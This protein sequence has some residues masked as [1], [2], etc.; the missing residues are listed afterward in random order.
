MVCE[1]CGAAVSPERETV[2]AAEFRAALERQRAEGSGALFRVAGVPYRLV[3]RVAEGRHAEVLLAERAARLTERVVVKVVR[4]AAHADRLAHEWEV[5]CALQ[6]STA[7]GAPV[8]SQWVPQPVARGAFQDGSAEEHP[9]LVL[10]ARSGFVHTLEH[11]RAAYPEGVD[12]RHATWMWRR[13]LDVLGWA[14]R[15]G[16]VHRAVE[17]GHVLIH[18][19]DHG[20]MLVGWADARPATAATRREDLAAAARCVR[21]ALGGASVPPALAQ[22]LGAWADDP[23]PDDDAWALSAQVASAARDAWGPPRFLPFS[24]PGWR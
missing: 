15:A 11:V 21:R 7:Q 6:A 4:S 5:L 13:L 16:W 12:P 23:P 9:A 18:A 8:F 17:P 22:L 10:R 14:H 24:M 3:G 19:R 1:H 2:R 20:V